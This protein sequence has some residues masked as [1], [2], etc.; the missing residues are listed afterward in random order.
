EVERRLREERDFSEA[1]L[2]GL[3][4]VFYHFSEDGTF[5]RWNRNLEAVSGYSAQELAGMRALDF[6]TDEDKPRVAAEIA[7]LYNKGHA[8]I[9]ANLRTKDGRLIPYL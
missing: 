1:A 4:G 8:E 7:A 9:E 3:S 5:L 2:N 6:F